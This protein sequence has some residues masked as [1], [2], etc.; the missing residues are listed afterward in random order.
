MNAELKTGIENPINYRLRLLRASENACRARQTARE[1]VS[2]VSGQDGAV[3]RLYE[4]LARI[5]SDSVP[6][7]TEIPAPR[8]PVAIY[9]EIKRR[10]AP[11]ESTRQPVGDLSRAKSPPK[12]REVHL[13]RSGFL[14]AKTGGLYRSLHP[15]SGFVSLMR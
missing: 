7:D 14:P 9:P 1:A 5:F 2:R 4:T 11:A 13:K 6:P 10:T 3:A 15:I 8:L 12:Y